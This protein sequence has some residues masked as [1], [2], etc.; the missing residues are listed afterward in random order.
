MAENSH[1]Y[2]LQ[3][4]IND[5]QDDSRGDAADNV[6]FSYEI[7]AD[8][9]NKVFTALPLS[10]DQTYSPVL[11]PTA[12]PPFINSNDD[13]LSFTSILVGVKYLLLVI[14][15]SQAV[16]ISCRWRTMRNWSQRSQQSLQ[17][18][19]LDMEMRTHPSE[20]EVLVMAEVP[21]VAQA[22]AIASP[23]P[24]SPPRLTKPHQDVSYELI[25]L[26]EQSDVTLI[27]P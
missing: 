27:S 2:Y 6:L 13:T 1:G 17:P 15:F 8:H 25:D 21:I 19:R 14:V 20:E 24:T 11:F 10:P 3:A 7:N 4:Y 12:S 23:P 9:G 26:E 18:P 5:I 16:Y 22:V